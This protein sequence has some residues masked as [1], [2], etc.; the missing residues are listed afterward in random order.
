MRSLYPLI[1]AHFRSQWRLLVIGGAGFLIAGVLLASAPLYLSTTREGNLRFEM[2]QRLLENLDIHFVVLFRPME[3]GTYEEMNRFVRG[4]IEEKTDWFVR[5]VIQYGNTEEFFLILPEAELQIEPNTPRVTVQFLQEVETHTRLV[6]GA[7]WSLRDTGQNRGPIEVVLGA[8]AASTLGLKVGDQINIIASAQDLSRKST[9]TVVGLAEPIEPRS[10]YWLG[11]DRFSLQTSGSMSPPSLSLFVSPEMFLS[12][13]G[14]ELF[15]ASANYWWFIYIRPDLLN[16]QNIQSATEDVNQL[17]NEVSSTYPRASAFT[18]L[19]QVVSRHRARDLLIFGPH[20]LLLIFSIGVVFVYL[21]VTGGMLAERQRNVLGLLRSRGVPTTRLVMPLVLEATVMALLAIAV[22]PPLVMLLV[23][24]QLSIPLEALTGGELT[25]SFPSATSYLFLIGGLT[26]GI[27]VFLLPTFNMCRG[28]DVGL[29]Q[30]IRGRQTASLVL[31]WYFD[32]FLLL[33]GAVLAWEFSRSDGVVTRSLLGSPGENPLFVVAPFCLLTGGALLFVR[34]LPLV[35]RVAATLLN[36]M[37]PV[38]ISLGLWMLGRHPS[39]LAPLGLLLTIASGTIVAAASVEPTLVNAIGDVSPNMATSALGGAVPDPVLAISLEALARMVTLA[40]IL[41]ASIGSLF[42]AQAVIEQRFVQLGVL[43]AMGMSKQE[44]TRWLI[45]EHILILI[46]A[47]GV[48]V[49]I[50]YQ[51]SGW[52]FPLLDLGVTN[53]FILEITRIETN[54][55]RVLAFMAVVS[56]ILLGALSLS[57]R[58]I[59]RSSLEAG[60]RL[61]EEV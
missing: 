42:A 17:Q 22:T 52:T 39:N 8:E 15:P 35:F 30:S 34:I 58:V 50:G 26:L 32:I 5:S 44:V 59:N 29:R 13:L 21:L 11:Y 28:N 14:R 6:D 12:Q 27:L 46:C 2:Q 61:G 9:M 54:W 3:S 47:L 36:T 55:F 41:L 43:Q 25:L 24:S 7:W 49:F 60:M 4:A 40:V 51:I 33:V 19:E 53:P 20:R 48:G 56:T 37:I 1:F 45:L 16:S 10:E 18:A 23:S 57:L 31:R 38:W